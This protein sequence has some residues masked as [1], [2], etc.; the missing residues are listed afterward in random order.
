MFCYYFTRCGTKSSYRK[1]EIFFWHKLEPY[2]GTRIT[3]SLS[4]CSYSLENKHLKPTI[5]AY[6]LLVENSM[7]FYV[8]TS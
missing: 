7:W 5:N 2:L 8:F 1:R 4:T 6:M 3:S